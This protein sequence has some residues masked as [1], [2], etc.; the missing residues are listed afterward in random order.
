MVNFIALY[1]GRTLADTELVALSTDIDIVRE[2]VEKL[3]AQHPANDD[4]VLLAGKEGRREAL[5]LIA[6]EVVCQ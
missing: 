1:R 2:F 6:G 4:P 5:R 3:L